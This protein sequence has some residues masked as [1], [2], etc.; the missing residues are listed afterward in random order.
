MKSL[1][2]NGRVITD[3][4]FDNN[5]SKKEMQRFNTCKLFLLTCLS[6]ICITYRDELDYQN[7]IANISPTI[8]SKL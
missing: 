3:D 4:K 1:K 2:A 5:S 8:N 6:E 7:V